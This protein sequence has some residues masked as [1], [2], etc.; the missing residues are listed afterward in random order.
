MDGTPW[1]TQSGIGMGSSLEDLEDV[2][3]GPFKFYGFEWDYAGTTN[4]WQDGKIN[5]NL[6]VVLTP[7]NPEAVFPELL[8]DQ[9]FSSE[10]PKAR[11]AGLK[12]SAIIINFEDN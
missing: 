4:E 5:K 6:T 3:G 10:N 1:K 12:V 2:N 7:V 9:L 11:E 8:G